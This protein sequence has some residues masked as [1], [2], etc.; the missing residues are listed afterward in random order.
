MPRCRQCPVR[1]ECTKINL[2]HEDNTGKR[3]V[4]PLLYLINKLI[5]NPILLSREEE[6]TSKEEG[7]KRAA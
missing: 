2:H 7:G 5:V 1:V 3:R 4:C 6:V